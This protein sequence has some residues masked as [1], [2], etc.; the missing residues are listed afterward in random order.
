MYQQPHYLPPQ[1]QSWL[2]PNILLT[3]FCCNI[4]GV[5]G[6]IFSAFSRSS[7]T[8]GDV[9]GARN[10]A[11][12]AALTF[13]LCLI[14]TVIFIAATIEFEDGTVSWGFNVGQTEEI[15]LK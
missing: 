6:I 5:F 7:W 1:P 2:I 14:A 8:R 13:W 4:L 15:R 3:I 9:H 11:R 10:W 12:V